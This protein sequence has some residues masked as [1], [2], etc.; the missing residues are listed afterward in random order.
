MV[1]SLGL[2]DGS[3]SMRNGSQIDSGTYG[4]VRLRVCG[5]YAD[6]SLRPASELWSHP[7][8]PNR[9]CPAGTLSHHPSS[10]VLSRRPA[11]LSSRSAVA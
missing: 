7:S 1:A 5:W 4:V 9:T 11:G 3:G 6:L 2:G 8:T 10:G